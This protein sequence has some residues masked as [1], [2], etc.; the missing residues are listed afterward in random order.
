MGSFGVVFRRASRNL[1]LKL[2]K[3]I[4]ICFE[5][6]VSDFLDKNRKIIEPPKIPTTPPPQSLTKV[7]SVVGTGV[8]RS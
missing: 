1:R 2:C 7:T 5:N 4:E 3:E 8:T 6:V